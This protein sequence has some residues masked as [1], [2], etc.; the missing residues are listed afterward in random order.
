MYR[1]KSANGA[2]ILTISVIVPIN[3]VTK[4]IYD[5]DKIVFSL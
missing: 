5:T 4:S 1:N 2:E 3:I